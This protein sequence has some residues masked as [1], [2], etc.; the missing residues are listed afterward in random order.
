MSE[1]TQVTD[2]APVVTETLDDVISE[3]NVQPAP[4][5]PAT[6]SNEPAPVTPAS[7]VDPLDSNQFNNYVSQVNSGQSVLN[8]Q[9]QEVKSELTNLRQERAE[10]QIEADITQAVGTINEGLN[11]DPQL[12]RVHLELTAQQK[13][14]FKQIWENRNDNPQAYGKALKALSRE[15]GDTYGN[16]QDPDLT[17]NQV[18]IQQSQQSQATTLKPDGSGNQLEDK[19]SEA[20]SDGEF[21]REWQRMVHG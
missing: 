11:L 21:N 2:T 10:L 5:Q 18:A 17:S 13:P 8:S 4:V 12:V 14:G 19:L 20:K 16:K 6:V 7:T 15:M 9:L 3:Y 1:D